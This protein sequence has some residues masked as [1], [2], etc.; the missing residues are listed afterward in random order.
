[1]VQNVHY[2]KLQIQIDYEI[3]KDHIIFRLRRVSLNKLMML[4]QTLKT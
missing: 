1:M 4:G 3:S 2:Y